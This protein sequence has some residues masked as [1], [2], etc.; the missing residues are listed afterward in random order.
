MN[1]NFDMVLTF[2]KEYNGTLSM[3]ASILTATLTLIYV[4]ITY[5]TLNEM[6]KSRKEEN[7]P[8]VVFYITR[9]DHETLDFYMILENFGKT[10]AKNISID[11]EPKINSS[12]ETLD[13]LKKIYLAPKQQIVNLFILHKNKETTEF[14][15]KITYKGEDGT[16]YKTK[17]K[18]N[19]Q[20]I[21]TVSKP[22]GKN[23][24]QEI[25]STLQELPQRLFEQLDEHLNDDSH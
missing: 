16:Q 7:R 21:S 24:L 9:T 15:C 17:Y 11:I 13:N 22:A 6:K 20:F 2:L 10:A 8:Y 5:K 14:N 18:I 19:M 1:I 23:Q 12:F 3:V 4:R 25:N